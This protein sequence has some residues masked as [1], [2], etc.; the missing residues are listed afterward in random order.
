MN[1]YLFKLGE[2]YHVSLLING[3][4]FDEVQVAHDLSTKR[5]YLDSKT[6][7]ES[8]KKVTQVKRVLSNVTSYYAV[9]SV[10]VVEQEDQY[11][12]ECGFNRYVLNLHSR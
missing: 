7:L 10:E 3:V 6:S 1:I 2:L 11:L 12:M 4:I 8:L 9:S 5:M